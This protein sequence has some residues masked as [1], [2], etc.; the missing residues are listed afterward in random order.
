MK[1]SVDTHPQYVGYCKVLLDGKDVAGSCISADE[2]KGEVVVYVRNKE[3]LV[4]PN[5][6]RTGIFTETLT[7]KVK[8]QI[9]ADVLDE[10]PWPQFVNDM[11]SK[12]NER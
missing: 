11:R 12:T 4:Q 2:E 10:G 3:G 5:K 9:S 8:I 1:I 6:N 7:G